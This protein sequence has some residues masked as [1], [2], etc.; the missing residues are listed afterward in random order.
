MTVWMFEE[1]FRQL[2]ATVYS[3]R[4]NIVVFD[5]H[6]FADYYHA[7]V[8][9]QS[10]GRN[11][12]GRLH[13]WMLSHAYPKPDLVICLDAPAEVLYARKKEASVEWLEQRRQQYL[14]LADVVP[15][16]AVIDVD[17][18]LD[19]VLSDTI[20]CIRAHEKALSE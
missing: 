14:A 2:V 3:A 19:V 8:K 17:R 5:R 20:D 4:G 11:A 6:F 12:S 9:S 7:D 1:W 10:A 13:G 16:F 15:A 18:S